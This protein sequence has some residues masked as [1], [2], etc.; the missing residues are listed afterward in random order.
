ML[1]IGKMSAGQQEYYLSLA[2]GQYYTQSGEPP[3][4]WLG[5]GAA[6]LGIC[7]LVSGDDL[8]NLFAGKAPDGSHDLIQRP[9]NRPHCPGWDLTFSAPKSVSVVW[10]HG[11][12]S[13]REEIQTA[14]FEA[15]CAA[16]GYL[17]QT[18]AFTRR[19]KNGRFRD[20]TH[21]VL[22]A[23]EHSTSRLLDP[24]LH[25]HALVLNV[26]TRPDGTTGTVLSNPLY[27]HKMAA[28]ALYR[29]ELAAQ[30]EQRLGIR[31]ERSGTSFETKGVPKRLVS[32]FSK[33]R[34]QIE[35]SLKARGFQT[36]A[37]ASVAALSTRET[38]VYA[39]RA[40]LF[41][42]WKRVGA[43]YGFSVESVLGHALRNS[44]D[45]E[46]A[47]LRSGIRS[48]I[49]ELSVGQSTFTEREII[50]HAAVL[51]Q[52]RGLA[53]GQVLD[54]AR[55]HIAES[56]DIVPLGQLHD[57]R[58]FTT[59]ETLEVE[60]SL[61]SAV[62]ASRSA[63]G[64]TVRRGTYDTV[65]A[66]TNRERAL[67]GESPLS[68]QQVAAVKHITRG[69]GSIR[70]VDGLAG[71]GKTTMLAAAREMWEHDGYRVFGAS[72]SGKA[73][74]NLHEGSGIESVTV[75][76]WLWD[77]DRSIFT[78]LKH[79]ITQLARAARKLPTWSLNSYRLD[80]RTVLVLD[81]AGMIGTHQMNALLRAAGRA[82]ATVIAV[83][84]DR[85]LQPIEAGGPFA[86]MK[87]ALGAAHLGEI[88]R[89]S[90]E[91]ARKA[92]EE[93]AQGEVRSALGRYAE[94]GQ[95][96]VSSSRDESLDALFAA[97][98]KDGRAKP[99]E[100]QILTT[101]N[102]DA[103]ELNRRAQIEHIGKRSILRRGL[104]V[105]SDPDDREQRTQQT[106][107]KGD[108][109]LFLQNSRFY[110]VNNGD[111]GTIVGFGSNRLHPTMRVRLDR[112]GI[113]TI[114]V[115]YYKQFEL[116]YA[117]TTHKS[118]GSTLENVFI[119][120]GGSM[121]DREISYVQ[122]SR[123]KGKAWIFTESSD[124]DAAVPEELL[125]EMSRSR[126]KELAHVVRRRVEM[127]QDKEQRP[128]TP[129]PS[130]R[131]AIRAIELPPILIRDRPS[132]SEQPGQEPGLKR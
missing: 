70:L 36:A 76:R 83:G 28:G 95:L 30:L 107:Y 54:T 81:E 86:A 34:L 131:P 98:R 20:R 51:A 89:Q 96:K 125:A 90:E 17:E 32:I 121:Q 35:E 99:E 49:K 68:K 101:T 31:T 24:Q 42:Q 80:G 122:V 45:R 53:A 27:R 115:E 104:T 64:I 88:R 91:W 79:H 40:E 106:Y 94:H 5:A 82:G 55:S 128:E 39:P 61:L 73:A 62:E 10:S 6:Q 8:R 113:R 97:W 117:I 103:R 16:T 47:R 118:Q 33:R 67:R 58:F 50:Q 92:V 109:V 66:R 14:H 9:N 22:A 11:E 60:R 100:N 23:F 18:A 52:G 116:G 74:A 38:K 72:L 26:G 25:T 132:I 13:V 75:A 21:L 120:A 65:L 77:L 108:R 71:T 37:A 124:V 19:G 123:A 129:R 7:G 78:D 85:Q 126:R 112:G 59:K 15:V 105:T 127:D 102:E 110:G 12:P 29:A 3:G 87:Q 57:D 69:N 119:L 84:D 48:I 46:E 111:L 43:E 63:K 56:G 4:Q 93:M 130:R 114:N 1:S 44:R 41:E 2:T